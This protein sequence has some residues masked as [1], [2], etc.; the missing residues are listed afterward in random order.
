MR[1]IECVRGRRWAGASRSFSIVAK[2]MW[3]PSSTGIGRRFRMARLTFED[4]EPEQF[5]E[6]DFDEDA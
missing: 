4:H 2:S 5:L 1:P 6:A 3:P